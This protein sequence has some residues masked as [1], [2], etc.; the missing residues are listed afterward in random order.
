MVGS[1]G[2]TM[3]NPTAGQ[4]REETLSA[5]FLRFERDAQSQPLTWYAGLGHTQR[6]PDY[7]ELFSPTRGP[8]GAP[9]AFAGVQPERTT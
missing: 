7:W 5:G 2:M 8:A 4:T 3:P 6:M 1:M 9:N